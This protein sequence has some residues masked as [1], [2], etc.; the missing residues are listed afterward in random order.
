MRQEGGGCRFFMEK[1]QEG[2]CVSGGGEGGMGRESVG[3]FGGGGG[4]IFFFRG[5]NAHPVLILQS[6]S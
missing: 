1:C 6:I 2:G 3:N 5:R 4:K